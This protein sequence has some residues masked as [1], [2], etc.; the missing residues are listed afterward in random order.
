MKLFRIFKDNGGSAYITA[1]SVTDLFCII[2]KE[3][4]DT[5]QTYVIKE[6]FFKMVSVLSITEKCILDAF[7][8][9]GKILKIIYNI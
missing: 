4:H 5:G 6:N 9:K 7:G 2:H 1:S 3:I 8:R